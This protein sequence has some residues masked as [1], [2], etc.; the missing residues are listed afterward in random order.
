MRVLDIDLDFFLSGVCELAAP[1]RRPTGCA[2][3]HADEMRLFL[4]EN[5]GLSRERPLPGTVFETHDGALTYWKARMD[6][7]KLAAPFHVTHVDAHSD[8]GIGKP[9]PAFVLESVITRP[10]EKRVEI[11]RYYE[12]NK[13]D[14]A[15]Y[16]LFALAFR[17]IS[18]L[19]NVRNPASRADMP[20][21]FCFEDSIRLSSSAAAL[22]PALD[23]R[24][25][26]IPFHVF[27]DW[28]DFRAE[29]PYDLA[30]LALSPRY[31][32]READALADVFREYIL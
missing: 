29:A 27:H 25:P 19:D 11:G 10:P 8:L 17:W 20:G 9:G 15:N 3:W 31:A 5:C 1:G 14:E 26:E 6:A 13:L 24:E 4:E 12:E 18:S 16:L 2:P 21:R 32:P 22:I 23:F 30:T 28:R 7:G